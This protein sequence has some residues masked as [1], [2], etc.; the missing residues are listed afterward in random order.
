MKIIIAGQIENGGTVGFCINAAERLGIRVFSF[1]FNQYFK[2]SFF[3]RIYNR[4]MSTPHYFNVGRLNDELVKKVERFEPDFVLIFKPVFITPNT[5]LE[6]KKY[7]KIFSWYPDYVLFPKTSSDYFMNSIP[8]YDAHFSFNF[9]NV[10]ALKNMGA[11]KSFFLPCGADELCHGKIYDQVYNN[12][13]Y[14]AEIIFIGTYADEK[15]YEYLEKLC[16]DGYKIKIYGNGWDKCPGSSCLQKSGAVRFEEKC[17]HEMSQVLTRSK[18]AL[19]FVRE[20]NEETLACRSF[21]IPASGTFM[22][23]QRTS[24]IGEYFKEGEEADFFGSYEELK[25][26]I[27]FYLQHDDLRRRIARSGMERVMKKGGLMIDRM[28]T[29]V[30]ISKDL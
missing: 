25:S 3:N 7:S 5:I 27:D 18:I 28:R 12:N 16:C 13:Y 15:R 10:D 23:H 17:C 20:H 4:F 9:A 29:M 21:E 26:K 19:S 1:D 8:L 6:I 30:E 24:K 11:K 14:D 22:L 2:N